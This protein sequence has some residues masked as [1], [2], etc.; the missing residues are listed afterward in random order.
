[1]IKRNPTSLQNKTHTVHSIMKSIFTL[2]SLA[3]A[4]AL[5]LPTPTMAASK[6][7]TDDTTSDDSKSDSKKKD[8]YPYY[9]VVEDITPTLLTLKSKS[10]EGGR[11]LDITKDTKF[12]NGKEAASLKDVKKGTDVG[13]SC[14]KAE[15]GKGN[16]IALS[17]NIDVKQ[18]GDKTDEKPA[19]KT[20]S[21]ADS[22][23][24]EPAKTDEKTTT[25]K[26][27]KKK[28]DATDSTTTPPKTN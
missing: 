2:L 5:A 14:K 4:F 8:T 23:K 25:K 24:T 3:A 10:K 21:K 9:G 7:K 22:S 19:A 27:K 6:K 17:I 20:D 26:T 13:G 15:G 1:M 12:K 18:K 28:T 16:E 11:K